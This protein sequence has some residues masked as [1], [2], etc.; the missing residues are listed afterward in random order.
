MEPS[1]AYYK[2]K[3][4]L[5]LF[6]GCLLLAVFVGFKVA[7]NQLK[8]SVLP[9]SLEKPEFLTTI[10]A[11]LVLFYLFQLALQWAA[12]KSEVQINQFHRIDFAASISIG[13]VALICYAGS[14]LKN[15]IDAIAAVL[16]RPGVATIS[17]V[18]TGFVGVLLSYATLK[19]STSIG[20]WIKG[21]GRKEDEAL[22]KL[23]MSGQWLLHYNP[24]D[25][26]AKKLITFQNDGSVGEGRNQNESG[27]RVRER[28][29]EILNNQ[30]EV[31]SRFTLTPDGKRFIHTNDPDT[32]SIRSQSITKVTQ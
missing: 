2:T 15:N 29:L 20:R 14:I 23:A 26:T 17:S 6:I 28:M 18:M 31:F 8:I 27:W 11:V 21:V 24:D 10:F 9:F 19:L 13:V 30:G 3:R 7:D 4:T 1:D 25:P 12:Q 5:L 32:L 16:N 22:S